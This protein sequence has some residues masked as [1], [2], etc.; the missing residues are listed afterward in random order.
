MIILTFTSSIQV[1]CVVGCGLCVINGNFLPTVIV[2]TGTA[3]ILIIYSSPHQCRI[4]VLQDS[5]QKWQKINQALKQKKI[6]NG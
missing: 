4:E 6:V 3:S 5:R 1:T 2:Y